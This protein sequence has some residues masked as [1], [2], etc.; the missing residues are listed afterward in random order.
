MT[1]FNVS[2]PLK[3]YSR[4]G[5][6]ILF[7]IFLGS[8]KS[9]ANT[10]TCVIPEEAS[11]SQNTAN[12]TKLREPKTIIVLELPNKVSKFNSPGC[13]KFQTISRWTN[14]FVITCGSNNAESIA[15]EVN[16]NN[17]KFNKTYS[18]QKD[19]QRIAE[20]FCRMSKH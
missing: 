8:V 1:N 7:F 15:L 3:S 9:L 20:G 11:R 18:I 4:I 6:S 2:P 19:K 17:L 14:R 5:A 13:H 12:Y 16:T 10:L